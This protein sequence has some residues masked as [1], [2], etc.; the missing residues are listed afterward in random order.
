MIRSIKIIGEGHGFMDAVI[1]GLVPLLHWVI[2]NRQLKIITYSSNLLTK[3]KKYSIIIPAN[4]V[5]VY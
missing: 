1:F 4:N 3:N 5:L 2:I